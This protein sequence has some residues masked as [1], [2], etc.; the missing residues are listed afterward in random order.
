MD[1]VFHDDMATATAFE[2]QESAE[3]FGNHLPSHILDCVESFNSDLELKEF[4]AKRNKST[5]N[6]K[7]GSEV[8]TNQT[9]SKNAS[10]GIF[11]GIQ[12]E[13][14]AIPVQ[15]ESKKVAKNTGTPNIS[16]LNETIK[17]NTHGNGMEIHAFYLKDNKLEKQL[18][19]F[20]FVNNSNK[21]QNPSTYWTH[22]PMI[23]STIFETDAEDEKVLNLGDLVYNT[24]AFAPKDKNIGTDTPLLIKISRNNGT[25]YT[26][27]KTML[28]FTCP[29]DWSLEKI[30]EKIQNQFT[31]MTNSKPTRSA[32]ILG[33]SS[34]NAKVLADI[35][36]EDGNYWPKF[37]AALNKPII[38]IKEE[39]LLSMFVH[40]TEIQQA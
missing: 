9:D 37:H 23:W 39:N 33:F 30:G 12:L 31:S 18:V 19:A 32:Y 6:N 13:T 8:L 5:S 17:L 36:L 40:K 3:T 2:T 21:S 27:E 28:Y 16:K 14:L 7:R 1:G 26:L 4:S 24:R 15:N 38:F 34:T 20:E 10:D 29:K 22:R 11:A 35:S 25:S